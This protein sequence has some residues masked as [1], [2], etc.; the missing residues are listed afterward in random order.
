MKK[1]NIFTFWNDIVNEETIK[2]AIDGSSYSHDDQ[3]LNVFSFLNIYDQFK[4]FY[5]SSKEVRDKNFSFKIFIPEFRRR[6]EIN[7]NLQNSN[8]FWGSGF[9]DEKI[10]DILS[11]ELIGAIATADIVI[12]KEDIHDKYDRNF[13]AKN[14]Y[15]KKPYIGKL[16]E[17]LSAIR[18]WIN[19][20]SKF[21]AGNEFSICFSNWISI[22]FALKIL[23]PYFQNAWG[24]A[25]VTKE[26]E[27]PLG[28]GCVQDFLSSISIR[29]QHLLTTRDLLEVLKLNTFKTFGQK[30]E[31]ISYMTNYYFGYFLLLLTAIIDSLEWITNWRIYEQTKRPLEIAFRKKKK[32][33]YKSFVK[34][35]SRFDKSLSDYIESDS[36][37]SLLELIYYLRNFFAHNILPGQIYYSGNPHGLSGNLLSPKG[38]I[39]DKIMEFLKCNKLTN[40]QILEMGIEIKRITL[41]P[42]DEEKLIEPILFSRY[43]LMRVMEF[44]DTI[45]KHLCIEKKMISSQDEKN[46]YNMLGKNFLK[47]SDTDFIDKTDQALIAVEASVP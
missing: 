4:I 16:S 32:K 6:N 25:V 43:I 19:N 45:F 46:K 18:P 47:T 15:G 14:F 13:I 37:Q 17:C 39:A 5:I 35:L 11:I 44:I 23:I 7:L 26:D 21:T 1:R 41:N 8:E 20:M 28:E 38:D 2:I 31:N 10:K 42:S 29:S 36:T 40:E 30:T 27:F 12:T 24:A 3:S 22:N 9:K 34:D 33:Y